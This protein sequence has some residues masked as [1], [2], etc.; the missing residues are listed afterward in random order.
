M[1]AISHLTQILN[2]DQMNAIYD[3]KK[4]QDNKEKAAE[5]M[6][7]VIDDHEDEKMTPMTIKMGGRFGCEMG[8]EWGGKIITTKKIPIACRTQE[9]TME[10]STRN[11]QWELL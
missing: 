3:E 6:M 11:F 8:E 2:F 1:K 10:I 7:V 5:E 4:R 9:L